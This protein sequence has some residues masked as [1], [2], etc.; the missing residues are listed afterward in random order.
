MGLGS[1]RPTVV[2]PKDLV[3]MQCAE[4]SSEEALPSLKGLRLERD[5][6]IKHL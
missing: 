1:A 5:D 4:C 2:R 3:D 6:S